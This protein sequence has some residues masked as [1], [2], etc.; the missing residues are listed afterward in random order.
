MTSIFTQIDLHPSLLLVTP[1]LAILGDPHM[2]RVFKT[3]VSLSRR[4]DRE[5]SQHKTFIDSLNTFPETVST[6]I[7]MG[8]LFDAFRVPEE[9]ILD[10]ANAYRSAAS[11]NPQVVYVV[12]PG[13]HDL[14]RDSSKKS[15]FEVFRE[16]LKD[17]SNIRI[18]LETTVI[19]NIGLVPWHPFHSSEEMAKP[20]EGKHLDFVCGHWDFLVFGENTENAI[21]YQT[22]ANICTKVITGHYHKRG[23]HTVVNNNVSFEVLVSGSMQPYA[24]GEDIFNEMYQTLAKDQV[25][26]LL[27]THGPDHFKNVCLR[28]EIDSEDTPVEDINCLALTHKR[29]AKTQNASLEVNVDN[30]DLQQVFSHACKQNNVSKELR[31]RT[32]A[33]IAAKNL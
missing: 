22:L 1:E 3:G 20:L 29:L 25:L 17:V 13:N 11:R 4:G 18:P 26:L 33:Q 19:N 7:C 2:G 5:R 23:V 27:E 12:L 9:V 24:H 32:W 16:L 14:S 8:D 30:F 6:H 10:V 28:V 21:P 15:S 31:D